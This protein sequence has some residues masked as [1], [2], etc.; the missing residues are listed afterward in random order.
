MWPKKDG[1]PLSDDPCAASAA[2]QIYRPQR[3]MTAMSLA[4][5][6][7]TLDERGV[8]NLALN[9]PEVGNAYDGLMIEALLAS[10]DG[11]AWRC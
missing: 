2:L 8:A 7:L 3:W 11:C 1:S 9:R 4:P 6:L 5:V 10:I